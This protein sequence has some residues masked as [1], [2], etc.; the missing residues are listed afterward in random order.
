M[1]NLRPAD[2]FQN[3]LEIIYSSYKEDG[4]KLLKSNVIK[5]KNKDFV[6]RL[7]FYSSHY[8]YVDNNLHKGSVILE[9]YCIVEYKGERIYSFQFSEPRSASN[10][11]ELLT[12]DLT[13]NEEVL[14]Y[15][16]DNINKYFISIVNKIEGEKDDI[17]ENL[18]LYPLIQPDD[19]SWT[20][21]YNEKFV[22]LFGTN[23]TLNEYRDNKKLFDS[24]P[25]RTKRNSDSYF[26][27]ISS[28]GY[29]NDKMLEVDID[30][31]L[32]YFYDKLRTNDLL[33]PE[34]IEE[35]YNLV[36][37]FDKEDVKRRF[38]DTYA[39]VLSV[40]D[41][42]KKEKVVLQKDEDSLS[43]LHNIMFKGN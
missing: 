11:F 42:L 28:K 16:T 33:I 17:F 34:Y 6:Y 10:R 18:E 9:V 27:Y 35:R 41:I 15:I 25:E 37:Q 40:M 12:A 1:Q 30:D 7:S 36:Q 31:I 22:E 21:Q 23:D 19:Y 26:Y 39:F 14:N 4:Y 24:I 2:Y 29:L 32:N 43:K 8:N 20:I 5:K 3:A 13:L 38:V